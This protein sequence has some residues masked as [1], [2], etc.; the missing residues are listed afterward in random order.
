MNSQP[1]KGFTLIELMIIVAITVV[2]AAVALSACLHVCM[3]A[4]LHDCMSACLHVC[5]SACLHVC[6]SACQNY[7]RQAT[8]I[9]LIS[10]SVVLKVPI[11]M[12]VQTRTFTAI[13]FTGNLYWHHGIAPSHSA[14]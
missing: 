10:S 14:I 7:A 2:L 13:S 1:S 11:E 12:R 4:C 5:M 8:F 3:S 6:M 9:Q